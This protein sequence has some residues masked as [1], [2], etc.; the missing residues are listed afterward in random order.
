MENISLK[1]FVASDFELYQYLVSDEEVMKYVS[2]RV[3]STEENQ[4]KF[5]NL[6]KLNNK[7]NFEGYFIVYDQDHLVGF[8]KI[9]E[10]SFD[11]LAYE[12]GYILL[13]ENW[14]KG[15][16]KA[17]CKKLIEEVYRNEPNAA[18]IGIIDPEN[19]ASKKI[20]LSHGFQTYFVGIEDN[21]PTEKLFV[22]A[23]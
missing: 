16:G 2:G 11:T 12:V 15:Y 5:S 17:V 20:L 1:K 7:G 22:P 19:V 14:G 6:I 18:L 4:V 9:E 13:K 21:L 10:Y 3:L 23:T 8:T